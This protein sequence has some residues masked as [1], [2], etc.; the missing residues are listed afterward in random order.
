MEKLWI[1]WAANRARRVI[2][3]DPLSLLGMKFRE[4]DERAQGWRSRRRNLLE[5][6]RRAR[7][8]HVTLESLRDNAARPRFE[9][10]TQH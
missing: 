10:G 4:N 5:H 6:L 1:G 8:L 9:K 2:A 3:F 7:G